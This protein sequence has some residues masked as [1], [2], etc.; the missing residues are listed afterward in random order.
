MFSSLLLGLVLGSATAG[1]QLPVALSS[2]PRL[3][4]NADTNEP[5]AYYALANDLLINDP[6]GPGLAA[7]ETAFV[8]AARL[9][10]GSATPYYGW[11]LAI[12]RPVLRGAF[13]DRADPRRRIRERLTLRRRDLL[14]SLLRQ[15][16]L[17]EPFLDPVLDP[18]INFGMPMPELVSNPELKG[19][20]AYQ[21]GQFSLAAASWGKTLREEP[22]RFDLRFH[23][24]HVY[25]RSQ[26]FDSAAVELERA[27][28]VIGSVAAERVV[29]LSPP[30]D[31]FYYAIGFAREQLGDF[32]GAHDAYAHALTEN[33]GLYMAHVRLAHMLLSE[34]DTLAG[35]TELSLAGDLA[36]NDPWVQNYHG[37]ALSQTGRHE[38]AIRRLRVATAI[39]PWYATPYYVRGQSFEALAQPREALVQYEAFL[40]RAAAGDPRRSW[41]TLRVA[42]LRSTR[43]DSLPHDD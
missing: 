6:T 2:R 10:P 31:M 7:A 28:E 21:V 15:A 22:E 32:T 8:W 41:I 24:A 5:A 23:R 18:S 12:L 20:A 33:L 4:A 37:F 40:A 43:A 25:Y 27:L 38:A 26:H 36:P 30:K 42:E 16:W 39:D 11:A 9:D 29:V 14:D 13:V 3:R 1:Y 19:F 35:L 17:R 34:G